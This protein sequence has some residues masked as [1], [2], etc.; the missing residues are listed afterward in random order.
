MDSEFVEIP[1]LMSTPE[2]FSCRRVLAIQAHYDDTDI[3]IGGLVA[4]LIKHGAEVLYVTVTDDLAGV[5]DLTLTKELASSRLQSEAEQAAQTLGVL[6]IYNLN[7]P[8]AGD[9][10]VFEAR[11]DLIT[12]IRQY[13]PD[14]VLALD[15]W[16]GTEA[17][18]D[19]Y[20]SGYAA[21]EAVI[22]AEVLGVAGSELE[23]PKEFHGKN[24]QEIKAVG[25][26]NSSAANI[27]ID[28]DQVLEIKLSAV[29]Q[30]VSQFSDESMASMLVALPK[31]SQHFAAIGRSAGKIGNEVIHA[32]CLKV[33]NPDALHAAR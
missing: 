3:A 21:V 22:L 16:L 23:I 28:I 6:G 27:F 9:W 25:L 20:K 10:S 31:R 5:I 11:R 15:P 4:R 14:C 19:H 12:V 26:Y 1:S 17:H 18:A 24:K 7:Y 32:E 8:D 2:I 33:L 30:Y 29:S 13:Q